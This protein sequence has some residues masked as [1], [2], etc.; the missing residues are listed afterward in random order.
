MANVFIV[1]NWFF[2]YDILIEAIFAIITAFVSF[3]SYKIYKLCKERVFKIFSL[4]FLFFAL[5]YIVQLVFNLLILYDLNAKIL[6]TISLSTISNL[7]FIELYIHGILFITGLLLLVY[8]SLR[9]TDLK[10]FFLMFTIL[11]IS[12]FFSINKIFMIYVLSSLLLLYLVLFFGFAYFYNRKSSTLI[13]TIAMSLLFIGVVHFIF[14]V[15]HGLFYVWGHFVEL[16]AYGLIAVDL[17]LV[18]KHGKEACSSAK[19]GKKK[20]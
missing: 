3:K 5:A 14:A 9:I 19:N 15:N 1:P 7:T 16:L 4:A 12:I 20:R 17:Y 18:L 2:G 11:L 8:N 13:L 6:S 10:I